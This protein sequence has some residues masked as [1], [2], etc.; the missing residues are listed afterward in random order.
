MKKALGKIGI[1]MGSQSDWPFMQPCADML[2]TLKIPFEFGVVSAHRTPERMV[3]Y[4]H[5][6]ADRGLQI[7]IACA[8]GSAHLP[9]M[10]ASETLLPTL[11]VAPKKDDVHA[12]GSMIAMP[13]GK[14]LAYMGGGSGPSKNAGATNAA[15][16]AANILALGDSEIRN[17]LSEYHNQLRDSVPFNCF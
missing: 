5:T 11:G 8:G 12:V 2:E 10:V 13:A 6:A 7:I 15:L 14:P 9:G 17:R 16:M 3:Q 1:I 4:A